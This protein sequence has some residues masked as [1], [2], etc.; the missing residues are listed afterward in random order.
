MELLVKALLAQL[1][2]LEQLEQLVQLVQLVGLDQ[3]EQ[4]VM[5]HFGRIIQQ[6]TQL[7]YQI[8]I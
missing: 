7:I 8:E 5:L 3:L 6:E 4:V 1:V 2:Q